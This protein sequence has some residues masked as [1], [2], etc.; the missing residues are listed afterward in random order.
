M[1]FQPLRAL[2]ETQD[3]ASSL[4]G[5]LA[6]SLC[7]PPQLQALVL[8]CVRHSGQMFMKVSRK[9]PC[10]FLFGRGSPWSAVLLP[11]SSLGLTPLWISVM[12][13]LQRPAMGLSSTCAAAR[14]LSSLPS[15]LLPRRE[16]V[17]QFL[18]VTNDPSALQLRAISAYYLTEFLKF[19]NQGV[20]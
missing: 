10:V 1:V 3:P 14:A 13:S 20:A 5:H 15:L 12:V 2:C 9:P 16:C 11:P 6:P 4:L 8:L 18:R 19:R 7:F 17:S